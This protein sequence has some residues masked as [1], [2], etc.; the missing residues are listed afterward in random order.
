MLHNSIKSAVYLQDSA[1]LII[2][3]TLDVPRCV[4]WLHLEEGEEGPNPN[5]CLENK[6]EVTH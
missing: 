3:Q 1:L 4:E 6:V 5:P 2:P